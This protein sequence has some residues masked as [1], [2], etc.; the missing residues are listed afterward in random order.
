MFWDMLEM[1]PRAIFIF[2]ICLGEYPQTPLSTA[3]I[4]TLYFTSCFIAE[5]ND[6]QLVA[7]TL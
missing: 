5:T 2:K 7:D 3:H 6:N 4:R 1:P